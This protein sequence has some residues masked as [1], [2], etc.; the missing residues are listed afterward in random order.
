MLYYHT[1]KAETSFD[2]GDFA[3]AG[4][5]QLNSNNS[6]VDCATSVASTR[7]FDCTT[8]EDKLIT[9]MRAQRRHVQAEPRGS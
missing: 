6:P 7:T 9:H 4:L 1:R 2:M 8:M 5:K 3:V